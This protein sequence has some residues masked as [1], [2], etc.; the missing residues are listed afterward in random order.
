MK[1]GQKAL[2][3]ESAHEERL[4]CGL[5][6]RKH[7]AQFI[8]SGIAHVHS[9]H[10]GKKDSCVQA[11]KSAL[12]TDHLPEYV[13]EKHNKIFTLT[14]KD[15]LSRS[16][17]IQKVL[18]H[19]EAIGKKRMEERV[20]LVLEELLSNGFYH[21]YSNRTGKNKYQRTK[22][23]HL[24]DKEALSLR[25]AF[26]EDGIFIE[27]T[28]QGGKLTFDEVASALSRCYDRGGKQIEDKE[29]GAG[30][31]TYLVLEAVSHLKIVVTAGVS[32][33][34]SCWISDRMASNHADS[35]SFNFFQ[36]SK[37]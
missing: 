37:I 20:S 15:S 28:D 13:W 36:K 17:V 22:A 10:F 30:L 9:T 35:F 19:P 26:T 7:G 34:V 8:L 29:S 14:L 32:T 18:N 27:V 23:A 2:A 33:V 25:F 31:G 16:E 6:S 3:P 24:T 11:T 12:N 5:F 4:I 21:A 1:N